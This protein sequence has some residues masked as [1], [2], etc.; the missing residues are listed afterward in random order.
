MNGHCDEVGCA[1]NPN[2]ELLAI[3]LALAGTAAVF[4]V[5]QGR[6]P[7]WLTYPGIV[8]GVVLRGLLLGWKGAG[9]AVVGCLLAGGV[10]LLFYLVRAMGGGDVKL[11][12]ALGSIIGPGNAVVMLVA[13]ALCG[14]VLAL[15]YAMCGHRIRATVRNL[16]TVLRFHAW[17]G[18]RAHPEL[19]LDNPVALRM[20]YGLAIVAGTLYAF[21]AVWWR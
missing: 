19:N 11:A 9:S 7:N 2:L 6:I 8:S 3:A 14:G 12:A 10:F 5:R 20:P 15:V 1:M 18:M 16:G 17:A 4:D 13:T 21:L